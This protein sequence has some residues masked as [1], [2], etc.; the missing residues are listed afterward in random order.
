MILTATLLTWGTTTTWAQWSAPWLRY[1]LHR[2]IRSP[3]ECFSSFQFHM[4]ALQ[5]FHILLN[6][7]QC[8]SWTRERDL[9]FKTDPVYPRCPSPC[10]RTATPLG[11]AAI[12]WW[13]LWRCLTVQETEWHSVQYAHRVVLL[14]DSSILQISQ[15]RMW[16]RRTCSARVI[17]SIVSTV[18][19]L[20]VQTL[21]S[22]G[23]SGSR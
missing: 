14:T 7:L 10:P 6:W 18:R 11:T 12:C 8:L 17:L 3:L 20:T 15:P 5:K 9:V 16:T 19:I 23:R 21:L 22:T 4:S 2:R 13:E 1:L